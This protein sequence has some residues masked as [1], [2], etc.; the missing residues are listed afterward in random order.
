VDEHKELNC[1]V[2]ETPSL[3]D[4]VRPYIKL[5]YKLSDGQIIIENLDYLS[6]PGKFIFEQI[7]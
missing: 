1:I 3:A 5:Y 6:I 7:F 2:V 4:A